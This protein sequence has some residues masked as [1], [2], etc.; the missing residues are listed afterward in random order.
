VK[1]FSNYTEYVGG[2]SWYMGV[3]HLGAAGRPL[4]YFD[5]GEFTGSEGDFL[6]QEP[7]YTPI[8]TKG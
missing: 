3:G 6:T 1:G 7:P 2:K 8:Q 5:S 4:A